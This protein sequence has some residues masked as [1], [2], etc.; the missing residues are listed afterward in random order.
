M[1][2]LKI[3]GF[4]CF[5]RLI[6]GRED[7][8][9]VVF[10]NG[11]M[12]PKGSWIKQV[13]VLQKKGFSILLFEYRGQWNS[14]VTEGPYSIKLHAE[15]L[16][17]LLIELSID[18]VNLVGTSY[19]GFV[20]MKYAILYPDDVES[21]QIYASSSF[22]SIDAKTIVQRWKECAETKKAELLYDSMV[23]AIFSEQ[24]MKNNLEMLQTRAAMLK[25]VCCE[26][27]FNGQVKLNE[28][29]INDMFG[30]GMT[31]EIRN[32]KCPTL[33]V[34]AEND[35]LYP[36]E[37]SEVIAHNIPQSQYV[38]VPKCGHAM[39][40]EKPDVVNTLMVGFLECLG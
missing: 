14:E 39:L 22:M 10:L 26:P 1:S 32:I 6:K 20:G 25:D 33:V 28:A 38:S 27:F 5:Y 16:K 2:F 37:C 18:K 12:S 3:N 35:K 13:E 15:D 36:P 17:E 19:G 9:T 8:P 31:A 7:R 21:I 40:I 4:E 23:P 24:Y 34:S 29:S 30:A 11:I